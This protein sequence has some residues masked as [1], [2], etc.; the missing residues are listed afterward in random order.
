MDKLIL[1]G[2]V[3]GAF[4]VKGEVRLTAYTE[5]PESLLDYR[6]LLDEAGA[7]FL[8]LSSGRASKGALL[9]RAREVESREQAEAL[10]GRP[11][12]IERAALPPP[13]EEDEF[14][15]ADL[16]GAEAVLAGRPAGRDG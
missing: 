7:P 11:L 5:T 3:A 9:A 15:L 13:S 12:Y 1:V 8:T 2:R 6:I 14:Y 4:G 10:R 16:I